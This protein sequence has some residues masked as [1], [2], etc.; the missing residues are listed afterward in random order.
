MT[1]SYKGDFGNWDNS[2]VLPGD[3]AHRYRIV[4]WC[5]RGHKS[6]VNQLQL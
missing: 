5:R 4:V 3:N 2:T 6:G 1:E